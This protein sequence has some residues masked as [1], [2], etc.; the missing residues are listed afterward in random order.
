[1][2]QAQ[3][4]APAVQRNRAADPVDLSL[5]E[6]LRV[7]D[8]ARELRKDRELAEQAL[9]RDEVRAQLRNKLM[10]TAE[11]SGDR[12]TEAEIDV[13][14]DTYFA[15]RHVYQDP[16]FSPSVMV[17]HLWVRRWKLVAWGVVGAVAAAAAWGLFMAPFAP[18]VSG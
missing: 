9:A 10:R 18:F 12:V 7:M 1:M 6:M 13:A 2:S 14:I 17:A 8:V 11:L 4:P 15:N 3:Q 5:N 16:A